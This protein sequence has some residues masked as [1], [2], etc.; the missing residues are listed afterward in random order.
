MVH[1]C[2]YCFAADHM[3]RIRISA[4]A[5]LAVFSPGRRQDFMAVSSDSWQEYNLVGGL[6]HV[7][8]PYIG[9]NHPN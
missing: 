9:N 4:L 6:E 7:Y 1:V 5:Q 2:F 8:F 3:M